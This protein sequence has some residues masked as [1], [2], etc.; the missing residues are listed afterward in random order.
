MDIEV[1]TRTSFVIGPDG[2]VLTQANLPSRDTQ[3]WV[4]RRKAEVVL[5]VR[6]GLLRLTDACERYTIS[7]EEFFNW[8]LAF[9]QQ[10]VFGLR[11]L[12]LP[13]RYVTSTKIL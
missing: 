3:R 8:D 1:K 6:G 11:A 10:G 13:K 12:S 2:F 7:S 4:A 9:E 5:A